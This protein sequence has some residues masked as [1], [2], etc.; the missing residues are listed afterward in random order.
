M[1]GSKENPS[2]AATNLIARL[3]EQGAK[4]FVDKLCKDKAWFTERGQEV[5]RSTAQHVYGQ[6]NDKERWKNTKK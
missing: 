1:N 3:G 5:N 2:T 4:E 6:I